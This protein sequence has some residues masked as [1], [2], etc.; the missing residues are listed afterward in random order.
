MGVRKL[1]LG[2]VVVGLFQPAQATPLPRYGL[3]VFSSLCT[4]YMTHDLNG[5]RLVLVRLPVSDTGYMQGGDGGFSSEPLQDL[6]IDDKAGK[7]SFRCLDDDATKP[8]VMKRVSSSIDAESVGLVTWDGKP[9]R[10]HRQWN[11]Q[12]KLPVCPER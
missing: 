8:N 10:L 11:V 1:V 7:I 6:K 5:D 9:F 2:L 3:I 4:D 12:G